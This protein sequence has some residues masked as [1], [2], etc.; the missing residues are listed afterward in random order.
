MKNRLK[1]RL[2][3]L[4]VIIVLLVIFNYYLSQNYTIIAPG[5]TVE[6]KKIVTVDTGSKA[7]KGFFF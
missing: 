7:G 3:I 5:V 2:R 6:L 4:A 1:K